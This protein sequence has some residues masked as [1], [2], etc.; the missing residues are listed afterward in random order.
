M[1]REEYKTKIRPLSRTDFRFGGERGIRPVLRNRRGSALRLPRSLIHSLAR[2]NPPMHSTIKKNPTA[3][4][5]FLW[6]REGDSNPRRV[7]SPY[8]ISSRAP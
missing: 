2:S 3:W 5:S 6:R 7:I 8:T 4:S 1:N